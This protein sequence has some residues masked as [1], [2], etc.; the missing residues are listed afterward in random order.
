[1]VVYIVSQRFSARALKCSAYP[2][3]SENVEGD[4]CSLVFGIRWLPVRSRSFLSSCHRMVNCCCRLSPSVIRYKRYLRV[5]KLASNFEFRKENLPSLA[6][7][8]LHINL[9]VICAIQII[10]ATILVIS[11]SKLKNIEP[12]PVVHM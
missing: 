9:N 11:I 1:M 7:N 6:G 10:L 8:V 4:H 2:R 12:L 3:G 5:Q